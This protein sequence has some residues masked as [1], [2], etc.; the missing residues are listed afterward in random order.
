MGRVKQFVKKW[1]V[2]ILCTLMMVFITLSFSFV[3]LMVAKSEH[4]VK[5][6]EWR[7]ADDPKYIKDLIYEQD[8][9]LWGLTDADD[10]ISITYNP[11]IDKY[12]VFWKTD[13]E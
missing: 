3:V 8:E 9:N 13:A 2:E 5:Y 1:Y 4:N 11:N 6:V 12:V 7:A 10:I